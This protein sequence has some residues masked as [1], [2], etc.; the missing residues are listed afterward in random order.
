M[1]NTKK[2]KNTKN[3]AILYIE[4]KSKLKPEEYSINSD[5]IE[6]LPS[7]VFLSYTIQFKGQAEAMREALKKAGIKIA[8]FQQILGCTKLKIKQNIAIILISNGRFH[9]LNLALQNNHPIILY[10]NGNSAVVGKNEIEEHNE[11][12]KKQIN[13]LLHANNIGIIISLKPGQ[14]NLK[15]SQEF[16][17]IITKKHPEK[18]VFFFIS[19]NINVNE[20]ENFPIDFWI[21]S[22]CPG[23]TNDSPKIANLDDIFD[24]FQHRNIYF[25]K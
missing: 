16:R 12:K 22:A 17:E 13:M 25:Q 23:L 18:K 8:G 9:A 10:S 15:Q 1:K 24:F 4:A 14:E 2:I 3:P 21:N 11:R 20:F 7:E 6:K 19:S 5:F